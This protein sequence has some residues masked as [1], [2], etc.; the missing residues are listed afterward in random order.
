MTKE[1][2]I[3]TIL[4]CVG[5]LNLFMF[6]IILTM[7]TIL[8]ELKSKKDESNNVPGSQPRVG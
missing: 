1:G 3:I 5:I 7:W 4:V 6:G 8:T 2:T